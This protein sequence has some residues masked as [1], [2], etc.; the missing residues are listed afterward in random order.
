MN[1]DGAVRAA[2]NR[3][4]VLAERFSWAL[5]GNVVYAGCQWLMLAV[6]ARLGSPTM[7]GE[8]ALA[9]AICAPI[10][11]FLNLQL[12]N[13]Q[14]TDATEQYSAGDYLTLRLSTSTLF[15]IVLGTIV[16]G[17]NLAISI[18]LIALA[19]ATE[20]VS[21]VLHGLLQRHERMDRIALSLICKGA[22]GLTGWMAGLLLFG[23]VWGAACGLFVGWG[24]S[25]LTADVALVVRTLRENGESFGMRSSGRYG[26]LRPLVLQALPLGLVATLIS[27]NTNAPRY[28]IEHTIGT[29]D[30]G[31]FA[32]L[33][34]LIV[35]GNM[36][37]IALAQTASPRLARHYH[38]GELTSYRRVLTTLVLLSAALG[39]GGVLVAVVAG[40]P[41]LGLLY[42][43][44]YASYGRLLSGIMVVGAIGYLS[45]SLGAANT[46]VRCLR[47]QLAV[48]L[49]VTV[50]TVAL[51][52]LLIPRYALSGAVVAL[53]VGAGVKLAALF[54]LQFWVLAVCQR[55]V[56]EPA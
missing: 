42:G 21:D 3:S 17:S 7:V 36:I 18:F 45:T 20:S 4:S 43:P 39:L 29:H 14:A 10:I 48:E 47:P 27:L 8:F 2:P 30:L 41:L 34:Y 6:L 22:L 33:A 24:L 19:K 40:G 23:T 49:V 37:A 54:G 26:A 55:R 46:A 35:A 50:T 12:R 53:F 31:I 13:L 44:E 15:L 5:V 25:L 51:S 32:A 11:L 38:A 56:G 9:L 28:V 1:A 52:V 16:L